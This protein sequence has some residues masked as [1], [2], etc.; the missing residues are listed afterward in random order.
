MVTSS[1][2]GVADAQT[3]PDDQAGHVDPGRPEVLAEQSRRD[4]P[5]QLLGEER[6][7]L[8]G[9]HVDGLVLAAVVLPVRLDVG[10]QSEGPDPDR[11][12]DRTLV[13][14]GDADRAGVPEQLFD[15]ADGG[16]EG[17]GSTLPYR[18]PGAHLAV[19][20]MIAAPCDDPGPE[21]VP[22]VSA[23]DT[24]AVRPRHQ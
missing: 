21:D 19:G 11:A 2:Q 13:D 5:V 6:G 16:D 20:W 9:V 17:H 10:V 22:S 14:G 18:G 24:R 7:V 3:L 4:R 23:L 1:L 12:V 15:A 8:V